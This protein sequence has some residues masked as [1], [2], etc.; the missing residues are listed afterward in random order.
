MAIFNILAKPLGI[1]LNFIYFN[2][3][4]HN[5]GIALIIFT[6]FIRLLMLPLT[7]KQYRSSA[8]M[9]EIQPLM[10]DIQNRYKNDKEKMNQELMK[11]YQEHKYNPASG[12]LPLLVQMPV[13]LSLYT[14]ISKPLTYMLQMSGETV[15]R[16]VEAAG[17][18]GYYAEIE[19]VNYFAN[20]NPGEIKNLSMH[21]L[22]L[23][24]GIIPT[25]NVGTIF[26]NW[27]YAALLIIPILA[28]TT[29]FLSTKLSMPKTKEKNA[30]SAMQNNMLY[31]AP[32]MTLIFSF[33]FPAGLGLYWTVGNVI[34][35]TQQ[36]YIN[37]YVLKKKEH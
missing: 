6:I 1:F 23:D 30:A 35:I 12:C 33:G 4:F 11:L 25:Y 8:K 13:F 34:Q 18:K 24:L 32:V 19:T 26:T 17:K 20:N 9:Q 10:K 2:L 5:Y 37:K 3:S 29:T 31:I 28:V 16:L 15:T 7:I 22:G 27:Q 36:L 14:V 21:F